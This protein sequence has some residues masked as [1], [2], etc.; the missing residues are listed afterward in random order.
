MSKASARSWGAAIV[1]AAL[2]M[3][4]ALPASATPSA[5]GSA[6]GPSSASAAVVRDDFPTW[7]EVNA[8]KANEQAKQAEVANIT[9]LLDG[10]EQQT[11][12]L[13]DQALQRGQEYLKA[14]YDLETAT[15]YA[16]NLAAQATDATAKAETADLQLGRVAAQL[17][18]TGGDSTLNLILNQ[19]DSDSLLYRLGAMSKLTEQTAQVRAAA[20]AAKNTAAAL[21]EQAQNAQAERDR[22]EQEASDRLAAAQD[23]QAAAEAQLADA[24]ATSATLVSQLASLKNTT[25]D[26]ETAYRAGVQAREEEAAR[27]RAAAAE[28]ESPGSAWVPGTGEIWSP[29]ESQSYASSIMGS[30]GWGGDQFSCLVQL[31]NGESGWRAN[32]LNESSGAYGIPQS[33]PASKMSSVAD[34]YITNAATQIIWGMNYIASRYDTPCGAWS[35][36]LDRNPHWY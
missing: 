28:S 25:V 16:D 13:T 5:S 4:P 12:D 31:W 9:S 24:R 2:L 10:L 26:V 18:R 1:V 6:F 14:S 36:W 20:V 27:Q 23:A 8:A 15:T 33:L 3:T 17:Y 7:D 11:A 30:Y 29:S 22:L 21:T 35:A 34:D 32:A 19:N